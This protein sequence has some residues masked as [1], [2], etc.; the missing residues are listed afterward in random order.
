LA[1]FKRPEKPVNLPP[2]PK[3]PFSDKSEIRVGQVVK[4]RKIEVRDYALD[5][6]AKGPRATIRTCLQLLNGTAASK[7]DD[8]IAAPAKGFGRDNGLADGTGFV[9]NSG[10]NLQSGCS[11]ETP[12]KLV[13]DSIDGRS[14]TWWHGPFT[15]RFRA[16][17]LAF[18]QF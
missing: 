1:R 18:C 14:T 6:F 4:A 3:F 7:A 13:E 9:D 15:I 8:E 10:R 2:T 11:K 12:E 16:I 5:N 17:H